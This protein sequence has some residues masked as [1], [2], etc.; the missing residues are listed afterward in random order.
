MCK[1]L[2][3]P[4][5]TALRFDCSKLDNF[6]TIIRLANS[7]DFCTNASVGINV[8][9]LNVINLLNLCLCIDTRTFVFLSR[10]L[11]LFFCSKL[12]RL[13]ILYSALLNV[14][15]IQIVTLFISVGS[16]GL[17]LCLRWASFYN[18]FSLSTLGED[19][20]TAFCVPRYHLVRSRNAKKLEVYSSLNIIHRFY[21]FRVNN[22]CFI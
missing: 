17:R 10:L 16:H 15:W 22:F 14:L 11:R 20:L 4:I 21:H 18:W 6:M 5:G 19:W 1:S 13:F 12:F 8:W 9:V 2:F 7:L 3:R